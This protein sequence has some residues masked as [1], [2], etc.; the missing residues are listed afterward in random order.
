MKRKLLPSFIMLSAGLIA[1]IRTYLLHYDVKKSLIIILIV[2]VIFYGIG[3]GLKFMLD[4]FE[5]Q[6]EQKALDE[7][8]VIAKEAEDEEGAEPSEEAEDSVTKE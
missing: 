6:N 4:I 3:S 7:G 8:E 2:L 5:A 1:S